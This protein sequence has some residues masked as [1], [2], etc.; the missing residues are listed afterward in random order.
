MPYR[1]DRL[2]DRSDDALLAELRRVAALVD[3]PVLSV[4]RFRVHARTAHFAY[5][6]RFGSWQE[7]LTRAGLGHRYGGP[8]VTPKLRRRAG[9]RLDDDELIDLLRR[10]ARPDGVVSI[11]EVERL[12]PVSWT[13]YRRRFGSWPEAVR[14]AGLRQSN[15]ARVYDEHACLENL[16]ALWDHYGRAPRREEAA[17]PPSTVGPAAYL[18]R[19]RGW[20]RALAA[21]V[22]WANAEEGRAATRATEAKSGAMPAL[23]PLPPSATTT[24]ASRGRGRGRKGGAAETTAAPIPGPL[25]PRGRG[26]G[27][28][29]TSNH[30][31]K[32]PAPR[33]APED[34]RHIPMG[35]RY[36]VLQRDDF[37]C[38]AC[39]DSPALT[40]GVKLHVDHIDPW[41]QGGKS[42]AENLRTLCAACN[43]GKGDSNG[44]AWM[45]KGQR[46]PSAT[47]H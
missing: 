46:N 24:S 3:H 42:V 43:F 31:E 20:N 23:D 13:T 14:R 12:S 27:G 21:F 32:K 26:A 30:D 35:L 33:W 10:V 18:R 19:F 44:S 34:R 25:S 15:R 8:T 29:G 38:T 2:V 37:R 45:L 1:L 28:G 9:G 6:R 39:G 22:E 36:Q 16:R 5:L 17:K 47:G 41:S 11:E 40:R 4:Q 7:S